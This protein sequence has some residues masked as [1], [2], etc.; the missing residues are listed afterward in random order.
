MAIIEV[1]GLEITY[2]VGGREARA[3]DGVSFSIGEG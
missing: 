1:D 3:V 2:K